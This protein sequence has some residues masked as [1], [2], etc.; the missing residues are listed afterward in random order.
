MY[1]DT[2]DLA[3]KNWHERVRYEEPRTYSRQTYW[4]NQLV[5]TTKDYFKVF[6]TIPYLDHVL[7]D[8]QHRFPG[9]ELVP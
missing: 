5:E 7:T 9:N 4:S 3:E 2:L 8:L 1:N 6:L